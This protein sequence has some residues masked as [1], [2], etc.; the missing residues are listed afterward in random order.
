M[1]LI[2]PGH[3]LY[4]MP[5]FVNLHL[6]ALCVSVCINAICILCSKCN[7][8][9]AFAR[10]TNNLKSLHRSVQQTME[11]ILR[12]FQPVNVPWS[13]KRKARVLDVRRTEFEPTKV[14]EAGI[15]KS[16]SIDMRNLSCQP[17]KVWYHFAGKRAV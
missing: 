2:K 3:F 1:S 13:T 5:Y 10:I 17:L 7:L 12:Y 14:G 8:H 9:F 6:L 16:A 11:S 4:K 15:S